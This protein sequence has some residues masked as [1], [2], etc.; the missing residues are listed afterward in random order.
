MESGE[1]Y[2]ER[3]EYRKSHKAFSRR[4]DNKRMT[5]VNEKQRQLF[6]RL[7]NLCQ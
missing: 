7:E 2:Q 4:P 1:I 6:A 3:L 5:R